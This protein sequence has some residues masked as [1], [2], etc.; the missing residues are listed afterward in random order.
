MSQEGEQIIN[1][2]MEIMEVYQKKP[3]YKPMKKIPKPGGLMEKLRAIKNKRLAQGCNYAKNIA[4]TD[5]S[6]LSKQ[7]KIEVIESCD[8]R[9]RFLLKFKFAD[10]FSLPDLKKDAQQH[11]LV[12][13]PDFSKFIKK[14]RFYDVIFD[15]PE[16]EFIKNHFVHFTKMIRAGRQF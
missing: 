8:F 11:F 15:F 12:V 2:N 7:R 1:I 9:R 14:H 13:P 10:D 4:K 16:R 3:K 6:L 5:E